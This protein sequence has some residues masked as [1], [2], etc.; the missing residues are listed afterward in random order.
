IQYQ[1]EYG[2]YAP[3][4]RALGGAEGCQEPTSV[5]A[6]LIDEPFANSS[7]SR[8][9]SGYY[10]I[11]SHG[12]TPDAFDVWGV[13]VDSNNKAFCAIEDG[14]VRVSGP[15][16]GISTSYNACKALILPDE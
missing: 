3:N 12:P 4:I 9:K 2:K 1:A 13:P 7:S 15:G 10:Y 8:P 16:A 5:R 14:V 11:V 6:C